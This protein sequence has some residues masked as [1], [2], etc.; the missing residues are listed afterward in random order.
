MRP[1]IGSPRERDAVPMLFNAFL[2]FLCDLSF[3]FFATFASTNLSP[4]IS[5]LA[6]NALSGKRL[7]DVVAEVADDR[8][9]TDQAAVDFS[10]D[11]R[12]LIDAPVAE[13]D[14]EHAVALIKAN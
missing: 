3:S 14:L 9:R 2:L 10:G 6:F 5:R 7:F 13:F 4:T 1:S 8:R 12:I 11:A